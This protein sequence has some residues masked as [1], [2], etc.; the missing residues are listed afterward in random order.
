MLNALA[1]STLLSSQGAG[2]HHQRTLIRFQ[3]N[4]SNLPDELP[5]VNQ[6]PMN[7]STQV[8]VPSA[9]HT[10]P[11]KLPWSCKARQF[12][13]SLGVLPQVRPAS[14]RSVPCG[15]RRTLEMDGA[16]VKS[17]SEVNAG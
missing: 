2:A 17:I 3:G 8:G 12:R 13:M 15:A 14:R 5:V 10:L 16:L 9:Q 7:F 4:Y 11:D 6:A 1:F